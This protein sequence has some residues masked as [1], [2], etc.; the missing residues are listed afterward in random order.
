MKYLMTFNTPA[1]ATP[2]SPEQLEALGKFTQEMIAAGVV[3]LTGGLAPVSMGG[4]KVRSKGG[5][6][7]VI[8]GPYTE[9]KEVVIGFAVI[10]AANLEEALGHC[11]RFMAI[12]GDGDGD[13]QPIFEG[14]A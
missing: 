5:Q 3:K 12:A 4:A 1:D 13:I 7:A 2:P 10:E 6:F 11:Q 14:G 8:D 9:A